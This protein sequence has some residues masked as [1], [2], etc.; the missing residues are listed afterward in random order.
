MEIKFSAEDAEVYPR[1]IAHMESLM[2]YLRRL[3]FE[4]PVDPTTA[5]FFKPD[6]EPSPADIGSIVSFSSC[7]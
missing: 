4:V 7:P 3:L 5:T 1:F 6:T 2:P